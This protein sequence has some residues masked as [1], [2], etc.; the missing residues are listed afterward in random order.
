MAHDEEE[1]EET[2]MRKKE[3]AKETIVFG[4]RLFLEHDCFLSDENGRKL[5]KM[6]QQG[7]KKNFSFMSPELG[8]NE[9][10][11]CKPCLLSQFST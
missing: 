3:D 4:A 11:F 5:T 10:Y 7:K 8:L 6:A 1:G 2:R 9:V